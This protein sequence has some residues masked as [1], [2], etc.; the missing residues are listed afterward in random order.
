MWDLNYI[1]FENC[2]SGKCMAFHKFLIGTDRKRIASLFKFQFVGDFLKLQSKMSVT[3]KLL[4]S[5]FWK[6]YLYSWAE[7]NLLPSSYSKGHCKSFQRTRFVKCTLMVPSVSCFRTQ[8][9]VSSVSATH[10]ISQGGM[11]SEHIAVS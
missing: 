1:L 7:E 8:E 11:C 4:Q 5:C 3:W 6:P 2:V 10:C 9:K